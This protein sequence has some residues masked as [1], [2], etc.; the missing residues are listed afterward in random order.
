MAV[1]QINKIDDMTLDLVCSS[2]EQAATIE[3][4]LYDFARHD[5]IEAIDTTLKEIVP[6][7]E[8]YIIENLEIDLGSIPSQNPLNHIRKA[9]PQAIAEK[10]KIQILENKCT[11]VAKILQDSCSRG[12]PLQKSATLESDIRKRIAEWCGKTRARRRLRH[13][14]AR[15]IHTHAFRKDRLHA[16]RPVQRQ[17]AKSLGCLCIELHDIRALHA[18]TRRQF[19]HRTALRHR[20]KQPAHRNA[21]SFK[22]TEKHRRKP[23]ERSHYQLERHRAYIARWV[24]IFF[25]DSRRNL[26]YRRQRAT[27][28]NHPDGIR[29]SARQ[30]ALELHD[31]QTPLAKNTFTCDMAREVKNGRITQE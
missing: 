13:R 12:L 25:L 18:P 31:C 20:H 9:L 23:F 17:H 10:V 29:H 24:A 15:P 1:E 16:S 5:L 27:P 14:T 6:E 21:H 4:A 19:S 30:I 22:R 8:D 3:G 26:D 11:P 2:R 7:D 28:E